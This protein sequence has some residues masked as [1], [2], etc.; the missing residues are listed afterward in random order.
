MSLTYYAASKE[1]Q[2]GPATFGHP[3]TPRAR[4]APNDPSHTACQGVRGCGD[5]RDAVGLHGD[6]VVAV[7]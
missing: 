2:P 1:I 7:V 4:H 5:G 3:F 6:R